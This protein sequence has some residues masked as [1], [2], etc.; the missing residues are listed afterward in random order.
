LISAK[1]STINGASLPFPEGPLKVLGL[2]SSSALASSLTLLRASPISPPISS[3]HGA[4]T[5]L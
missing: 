1:V 4:V 5:S 2:A 3:G